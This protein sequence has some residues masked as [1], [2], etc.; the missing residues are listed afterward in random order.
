VPASNALACRMF[1]TTILVDDCVD[2]VVHLDSP[3][4]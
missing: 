4:F 3:R 2:N 1:R